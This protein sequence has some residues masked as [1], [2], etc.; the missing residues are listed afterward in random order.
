[1]DSRAWDTVTVGPMTV[2]Y[3]TEAMGIFPQLHT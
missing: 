2:V 1:M 3:L